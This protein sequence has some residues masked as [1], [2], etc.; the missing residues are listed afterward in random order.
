[1]K[2][3]LIV[4]ITAA[5]SSS[6]FAGIETDGSVGAAT[7]LNGPFFDINSNLGK[8][9][10]GNLFHSFSEFSVGN[11]ETAN[12]TGPGSVSNIIGRVSGGNASSI[13]G[14]IRSS[15]SD[16]DLYLINPNGIIFG[17]DAQLDIQGSFN[18]TTANNIKFSD[19]SIFSASPSSSDTLTVESLS[20]FGFLNASPGKIRSTAE[21]LAVPNGKNINIIGGDINISID[22]LGRDGIQV[23]NGN[24][25]I[26]STAGNSTVR[27]A[28]G[29]PTL[30]DQLGGYVNLYG[31]SRISTYTNNSYN[32]GDITIHAQNVTLS[33]K[34]K[35]NSDT[36]SIGNAGSIEIKSDIFNMYGITDLGTNAFSSGNAGSITLSVSRGHLKDNSYISSTSYRTSGNAGSINIDASQSLVLEGN[37][38]VKSTAN[39]RTTGNAGSVAITTKHL[40]MSG[41]GDTDGDND[42][43]EDSA[44]ISSNVLYESTGMGGNVTITADTVNLQNGATIAVASGGTGIAGNI[45]ITADTELRTN[46]GFISSKAATAGGGNIILRNASIIDLKNSQVTASVAGGVGGGG[47]VF[48]F[49]VGGLALQNSH[50]TADSNGANGGLLDL[51]TTV[52][53]DPFS[54]TTARGI[55][56]TLDGEVLIASEINP[57]NALNELRLDLFVNQIKDP[58]SVIIAEDESSL[59][60]KSFCH[61]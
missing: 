44:L 42:L 9:V 30:G 20:S 55:D 54:T 48:I 35:I 7:T 14:T 43:S 40:S 45:D 1:M 10:G 5:V 8:Q 23:N 58:C 29:N 61:K 16:A 25:S 11:G 37:A 34:A 26:I 52:V 51:N 6:A 41:N 60:I 31:N 49:D 57:N 18:A 3:N 22:A 39:S 24:I 17:K 19:G 50:I 12:F 27:I 47:N 33:D 21:N 32:A 38:T 2:C 46:T 53:R 13:N 28:S 56:V 36:V 59:S 15:I 4:F